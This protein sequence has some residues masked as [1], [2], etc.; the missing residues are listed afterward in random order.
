L[1][2][3]LSHLSYIYT[4]LGICEKWHLCDVNYHYSNREECAAS[5]GEAE[6]NK[7]ACTEEKQVVSK[8]ILPDC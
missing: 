1:H 4:K 6:M 3:V 5:S 2:G 8:N 7:M